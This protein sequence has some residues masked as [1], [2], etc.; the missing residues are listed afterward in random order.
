[1]GNF[2][3]GNCDPTYLRHEQLYNHWIGLDC[4]NVGT[5]I[6][7][8]NW[9]GNQWL[10]TYGMLGAWHSGSPQDI[11]AS[12]FFIEGPQTTTYWPTSREP[13]D[14]D[15]WFRQ[16]SGS[17]NDCAA[18]D[19]F[20]PNLP[21]LLAPTDP[22]DLTE[23]EIQIANG[24]YAS[25]HVYDQTTQREG[26]R[27]LYQELK[28]NAS[29]L[30]Q[31][32]FADQFFAAA[33]TSTIGQLYDV[34]SQFLTLGALPKND[35]NRVLQVTHTLDSLA[36]V[37]NQI[38][39]FYEGAQNAADST[40]LRDWKATCYATAHPLLEEWSKIGDEA[41]AALTVKIPSILA[42]NKADA[43]DDTWVANRKTANRIYLETVASGVDTATQQ[44]ISDL[45]AV[46]RQ[47]ALEGGDAVVQARAIY[48]ILSE[49]PLM[50]NDLEICDQG[51][52]ERSYKI[53]PGQMPTA[54][55]KVS[56]VPNP[57][58][59]VFVLTVQGVNPGEIL[60]LQIWDVNGIL[61][62]ELLVTN[63]AAIPSVFIPGLYF[64]RVY[65]GEEPADVV[66]LVIIP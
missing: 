58:R 15:V 29:L 17:S 24:T 1:V 65:V 63:G 60:R 12:E 40:V 2:F 46:A 54:R 42:L 36:Q 55:H 21:P 51:V 18:T 35:Y 31:D 64:C 38:D 27:S 53:A 5:I 34:E 30:G 6:G 48:N 9:A 43:A 41:E 66:K 10:G 57:A 37:R 50:F 49:E 23:N 16:L 32:A 28:T 26:E 19:A 33:S 44:Q 13:D 3:M 52:D 22:R 20:C 25:S 62:K 8:Q 61:E 47:C 11:V 45:L 56:V 14:A 7:D 39:L 59:D 4:R